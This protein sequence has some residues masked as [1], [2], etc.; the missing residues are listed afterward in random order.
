MAR[1]LNGSVRPR[2][3]T[4]MS[5]VIATYGPKVGTCNI[6]GTHGPLTEDHTPP[7]GCLK[8]TQV[9]VR[10]ISSHF[11]SGPPTGKARKSQNGVKY[12]TLCARCN[13]TLLGHKY[14]PHFIDFVNE[15]GHALKS[16]LYLPPVIQIRAEPQAILRSLLGHLAAQG[17]DRYRKGPLTESIRD[18]ILDTSLPFPDGLSAFYWAY[19]H[20]PQVMVRDAAY[21]NITGGHQPFVLWLLKFF[22]VAFMVTWG[23]P[24]GLM[25]EPQNF[26][27]WRHV[28][29]GTGVDMPLILRPTAHPYW[30]EAPSNNNILLYGQEAIHAKAGTSGSGLDK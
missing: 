6:C 23:E 18:Y 25:Y 10:H 12:R 20:K 17:V 26:N 9:E 3:H 8:P 21:L 5:I 28:A 14:D 24:T 15:I 29:Y 4:L 16:S 30:P 13:N 19:P 2:I 7:K 27:P 11:G 1:R 22:P